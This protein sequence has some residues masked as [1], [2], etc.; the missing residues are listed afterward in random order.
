MKKAVLC[1]PYVTSRQAQY[2]TGLYKIASSCEDYC[3]VIVLD[4]R[5]DCDVKKNI[6]QAITKHDNI[7]C[8]GLSVMTGEQIKYAIDI[9]KSF[10]GMLP[11]VWG[12]LHPTILPG[13]TIDNEFID[14][15]IIGEGEEAFLNLL[16]YLSGKNI[17]KELFLSKQNKNYTYNYVKNLDAERYIDFDKYKIRSEYFV[18]RDGFDKAFNFETS[19]GCPHSCYYC[20]NSIHKK[21]Y[22]ALSVHNTLNIIDVIRRDYVI[23]G[24]IF[25]EDNL[26]ANLKRVDGIISGLSHFKGLGWKGNSRIDYFLKLID[27]KKFMEKLVSSGCRVLQFGIES[28]SERILRMINK[29]ITVQSAIALNRKLAEFP[30]GIRYNFIVGFPSET[31]QN[32]N[33]TL[34]LID[35]LLKDNPHAEPPFVNV[36]NP[37][38][39]TPLYDLALTHGF[40]E[41]KHLAEW[42]KFSWH[43]TRCDFLPSDVREFIEK[44]SLDYFKKS[45]YLRPV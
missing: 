45:M 35:K 39:G 6:S 7:L 16:H 31:R 10:H 32:I 3:D 36:Y 19:R 42:A 15:I 34:K 1:F 13:Q 40:Q 21:P 8:L 43:W 28:G 26:F 20:H 2:P 22:R 33:N 11:I 24:V 14:Y 18:K 17:V 12:G 44:I 38:P 41:P 23:D 4:Q 30:I 25:Q 29:G 37:Y 5:L 9:S 27:N